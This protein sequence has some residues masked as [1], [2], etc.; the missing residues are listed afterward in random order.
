MSIARSDRLKP[1]QFLGMFAKDIPFCLKTAADRR[2]G[3]AR[4]NLSEHCRLGAMRA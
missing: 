1:E 4:G 3:Q 2:A